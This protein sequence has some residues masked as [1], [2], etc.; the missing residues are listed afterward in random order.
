MSDA[1]KLRQKAA[2]ARRLADGTKDDTVSATLRALA[3]NYEREAAAIEAPPAAAPEQTQRV[4]QQQQQPQPDTD[5][6]PSKE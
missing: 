4:G 3:D 1:D 5:D 6:E 2:Q